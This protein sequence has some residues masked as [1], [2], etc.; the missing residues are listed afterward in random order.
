MTAD[1][2]GRPSRRAAAR[3][4]GIDQLTPEQATAIRAVERGDDVIV[5]LPTGAGKSAIYQVAGARRDGPTLVVSPLIALQED[6]LARL[7]A[8]RDVLGEAAAL[9]SLLSEG[10]QREALERFAAGE[11]RYLFLA[12]EQLHDPEVVDAL[13]VARPGLLVVDESH[14]VVSWGNDFRPAFL[15][16]GLARPRLGDPPVLALTASAAPAVRVEIA[17]RLAM[18]DPTTVVAGVVRPNIHLSVDNAADH[19]EAEARL[20]EA[21]ADLAGSGLVYVAK[22]ADADRLAGLLDS[23]GR[24]A[25]AYHSGL[26]RKQR[27]QVHERF[28][29]E[30][31]SLVVATVAFGLGIDKPDVRF[32]VHADAPESIDAWYQEVGRAGR[33]GRPATAVLFRALGQAPARSY[34][35]GARGVSRTTCLRALAALRE[36]GEATV[37]DI[38][39]VVGIGKG[40]AWQAVVELVAA[41]AATASP[42]GVVAPVDPAPEAGAVATAIGARTERRR[43]LQRS[44]GEMMRALLDGTGCLW[45]GIAGYLGDPLDHLCAHCQRCDDGRA[46]AANGAGD[47]GAAAGAGEGSGAAD[48]PLAPGATITHGEFGTGTVVDRADDAV[49]VAFDDAGYRRLSVEILTHN[50]LLTD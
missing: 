50:D 40:Q 9:H 37:E 8:A 13:A 46:E 21:V 23:P 5:V 44:Q 3:A 14:C 45:R 2:Q 31:P 6:Q 28:L 7:D 19:D 47:A 10:R 49:T 25:L 12:P 48:D 27:T 36:A 32:V 15:A 39:R 16:I 34:Y 43:A 11:L 30:D 17:E 1:G 18:Q 4:L 38:A 22:R 24:P 26:T 20:V 33:D 35:G 42:D 29:A 41:G